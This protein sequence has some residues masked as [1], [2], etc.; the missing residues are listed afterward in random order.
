MDC[1][2]AYA[3]LKRQKR[4]DRIRRMQLV[5]YQTLEREEDLLPGLLQVAPAS[6][7]K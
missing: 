4:E 6:L 1:S 3:V 7:Q 2:C 5:D